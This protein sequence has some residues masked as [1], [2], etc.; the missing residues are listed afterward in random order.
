MV[1]SL[2]LKIFLW[3]W[4]AMALV[5]AAL[6]LLSFY[7]PRTDIDQWAR[8]ASETMGEQGAEAAR[9]F[10]QEGP[11]ALQQFILR[12]SASSGIRLGL[13][14]E[15]GRELSEWPRFPP[16]AARLAHRTIEIGAPETFVTPRAVILARPVTSPSNQQFAIVGTVPRRLVRP[17][18]TPWQLAF[19]IATIILIA[20]LVCYGLARYLTSPVRKLQRAARRLAQG[21]LE[22]RVG[23]SVGKRNDEFGDLAED[24]DLMA[25]RIQQLILA[26]RRLLGDISHELRSPLSRLTVALELAGK[27]AGPGATGYLERIRTETERMNEL[28]GQLLALS[29]LEN[30]DPVGDSAVALHEIVQSVV[31]DAQFEAASSNRSVRLSAVEEC[32]VTG[33][34]DLLRSAIENVV[35]NAIRYT[36]EQTAAEVRLKVEHHPSGG[37]AIVEIRDYGPGAPDETLEQIFEPFYRVDEARDRRSGG[38]GLGLAIAARAVHLHGGSIAASN[39]AGGGLLVEIRLP[40]SGQKE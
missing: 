17:E 4:L 3:F 33:S 34:A 8:N 32:T 40:L 23:S 11:I 28:I 13:F 30:K 5:S 2:F 36:P 20:G 22:T 1:N 16:A 19:R 29:R 14:D 24:F 39:A 26:Q 10:E 25:D 9:I 7:V 18:I 21:D 12:S 31:A 35:R 15:S 38:T 37:Q 27:N 6:V